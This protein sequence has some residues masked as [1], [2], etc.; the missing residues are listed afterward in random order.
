M[1]L[2]EVERVLV[3]ADH[4]LAPDG[5]VVSDVHHPAPTVPAH[6]GRL[7]VEGGVESLGAGI[8]GLFDRGELHL[9]THSGL[10]LYCV[11]G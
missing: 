7:R 9:R 2:T 5:A 4:G 3:H 1:L 6:H 8:R 10:T 11:V